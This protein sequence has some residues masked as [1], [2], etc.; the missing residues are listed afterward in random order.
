MSGQNVSF[1]DHLDVL[2]S[3]LLKSLGAWLVGAVTAFCLKDCIFRLLFAPTSHDFVLYRGL[4]RLAD[5]TGWGRLCPEEVQVSFLNTELTAQ[6]MAH[7]QASL[8][9]GLIFA[10]PFILY[11]LYGFIAPALYEKERRYGVTLTFASVLLFT[12]GICVCYF[13]IF[14][15][16]FRFLYEYQVVD[17]VVNQI[18][19]SSYMS[20]FL[21]LSLLMGLTFEIPVLTWLLSKMGV[22]DADQMR[23]YRKH[24]FTVLLILA[25]VITPTGDP[26]T[27][28]LVTLPIYLLYE[29]SIA[30]IRTKCA[31]AR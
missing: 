12:A 20:L 27:L 17:F 23:K 14:P 9:F 16:S 2:R 5:L 21:T 4:C 7:L 25:A 15:I 3:V 1:W 28:L 18:S 26:F 10:F 24:V 19:L 13:L 29:L 22:L 8:W 31:T 30:I 11:W 6:F